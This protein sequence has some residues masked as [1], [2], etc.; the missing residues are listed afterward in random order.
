MSTNIFTDPCKLLV[1]GWVIAALSGF[2]PVTV[3]GDTSPVDHETKPV[4]DNGALNEGA[5]DIPAFLTKG[6]IKGIGIAPPVEN[7]DAD[8]YGM[9][10][11]RLAQMAEAGFNTHRVWISLE[12]FLTPP[13]SMEDTVSKWVGHIRKSVDAGFRVQVSWSS[14]WDQRI[15][16]VSDESTRVRFQASIDAACKALGSHFSETDVALEMINEPP[17]DAI[18]PGYYS[19]AAP[20]WYR[21]CR[22][23]APQLTIILQPE[24]GWRGGLKNFDLSD[25]D[26]N[27]MFSFHPYAPGEFTHQGIG[28]QPHL[29]NVPMPITRYVGGQEQMVAD[30]KV[31]VNNDKNLSASK[32]D[33]E[34]ER[35]SRIIR[36]LWWKDGAEWEDWSDLS[37][38]VAST[39][40]NP[41][42]ILAGEFGVVSEH[43]FNGVAALSDVAS[44]G[45]Y[46]R[47][48]VSQAETNR[49]GGWLVHQALGD[50]NLF[51]QSAVGRHG[52]KLIPELVAALF[53]DKPLPEGPPIDP[54]P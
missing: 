32:K 41:K 23:A 11:I 26:A 35:Y 21:T 7:W 39:G 13:D 43:N 31:R 6:D 45:H 52:D 36:L 2:L 12:E 47:K 16:V 19:S 24:G 42:R 10:K 40:I 22:A 54:Q 38:W 8:A 49:F 20:S 37:E 29:Y 5:T 9:T 51:Q 27:T 33:Q 30:M 50:F 15:A 28:G 3:L 17:S 4:A 18:T 53:S 14:T 1:A 48:I 25:F 46:L 34:I 44:R